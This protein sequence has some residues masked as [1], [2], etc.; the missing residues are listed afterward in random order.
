M[1]CARPCPL[2][3]LAAAQYCYNGGS[4]QILSKKSFPL[5]CGPLQ[6]L[7]LPQMWLLR[8]VMLV[9]FLGFA[10][11]VLGKFHNIKDEHLDIITSL[12]L[13]MLTML[14]SYF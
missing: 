4:F 2:R 1:K 10:I 11:Q 13:L 5:V 9:L 7:H 12:L 6:A 14:P 3:P 8:A